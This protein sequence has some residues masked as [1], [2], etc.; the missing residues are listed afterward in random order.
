VTA[1]ATVAAM[2]PAAAKG[3][4]SNA[5]SPASSRVTRA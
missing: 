5:A 3:G 1:V 2:S 4:S